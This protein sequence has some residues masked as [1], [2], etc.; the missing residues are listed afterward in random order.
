MSFTIVFDF[1]TEYPMNLPQIR[2]TEV[3]RN[4][5][6]DMLHQLDAR[7]HN[8]QI[9]NMR[10]DDNQLLLGSPIEDG[11]VHLTSNHPQPFLQNSTQLHVPVT[12]MDYRSS[13]TEKCA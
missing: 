9:I 11:M 3:F 13:W 12:M 8:G 1:K 2:D 5:L 6:L 10:N 7:S 4:L